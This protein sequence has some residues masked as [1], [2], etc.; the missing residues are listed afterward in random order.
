MKLTMRFLFL[1]VS[2]ALILSTTSCKKDKVKGCMNSEATNYSE[3][4]NLDDGT[5][6]FARD[7]FLG[8]WSG[9]KLCSVNP[10]DS[11]ISVQVI[12]ITNNF[13]SILIKNFPFDGIDVNASVNSSDEFKLIIPAQ[14]INNDLDVFTISGEGQVY[15]NDLVINYLRVSDNLTDTCG[16]GLIK[17]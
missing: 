15:E 9:S 11:T 4:A 17:N 16:L 3:N 10:L 7:K 13:R 1:L 14:E 8:N 2:F 6:V 12:A 5:C